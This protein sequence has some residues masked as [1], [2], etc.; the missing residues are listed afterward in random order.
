MNKR[1]IY[2]K[3]YF[4]SIFLLISIVGG[5]TTINTEWLILPVKS[6][7][8]LS[9]L[10]FFISLFL[11][12]QTYL[13]LSESDPKKLKSFLK[14]NEDEKGGKEDYLDTMFKIIDDDKKVKIFKENLLS[15]VEEK[16]LDSFSS[17]LYTQ[18]VL[19]DLFSIEESIRAQI[20][21]LTYNS[22][23]N[24]T[25]G[26]IINTVGIIILFF[27]IYNFD[28]SSVTNVLS[29]FAPRITIVLFV[30]IFSFF[31]LK[32]YKEC[33]QDIKYF[34]NEIIDTTF[35]VSSIKLAIT[36]ENT[37]LINEIL[38]KF[39]D[40]RRLSVVTIKKDET[41]EDLERL[42]SESNVIESLSTAIK[43]ITGKDDK[44]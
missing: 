16:F 43:S 35:K 4:F 34:E 10:I 25:I 36:L 32:L 2:Y 31:F 6:T 29:Y 30:Q 1:K 26:I 12:L 24:L 11:I 20:K 18:V 21:R 38:K 37:E 42:K 3:L 40:G 14:N 41:T 17:E 7:I 22:N 15:K 28:S 27:S 8:I 23:L 13:D 5:Y 33:L 39:S 19:E 9:L 44:K